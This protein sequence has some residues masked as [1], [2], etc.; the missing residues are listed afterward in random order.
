MLLQVCH[1][2][3]SGQL[4]YIHIHVHLE[5]DTAATR[6]GSSQRGQVPSFVH[7]HHL[8]GTVSSSDLFVPAL[9]PA[10]DVS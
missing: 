7:V 4:L 5:G 10:V 8:L 2:S 1:I 3:Y 6:C 9:G